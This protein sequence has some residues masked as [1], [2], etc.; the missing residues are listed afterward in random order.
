[1]SLHTDVRQLII[2]IEA[3]PSLTLQEALILNRLK[4]MLLRALEAAR[5]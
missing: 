1:M 4:E 5:S 2:D 3:K